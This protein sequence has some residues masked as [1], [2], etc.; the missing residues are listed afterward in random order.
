MTVAEGESCTISRRPVVG[1]SLKKGKQDSRPTV[2][3]WVYKVIES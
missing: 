1:V 2:L 3:W